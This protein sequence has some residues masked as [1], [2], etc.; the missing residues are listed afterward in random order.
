MTIRSTALK[1]L[2]STG[3]ACALAIVLGLT[4]FHPALSQRGTPAATPPASPSPAV[5]PAATMPHLEL[6]MNEL[7]DSGIGGT[8]T[9]YDTGND[10]T[11]VVFDITEAGKDHPAHIHMGTCDALD[12]EPQ[13]PLNDV[14]DGTSTTLVDVSLDDLL[15]EPHAVDMHLAPD[16]LG[17]LIGCADIA[18]TPVTGSATPTASP[19]PA[20]S[21]SPEATEATTG[22]GT[23]GNTTALPSGTEPARTPAATSTVEARGGT[24]TGTTSGTTST[25]ASGKGTA[26]GA[27]QGV[28][29]PLNSTFNSG[30]NGTV[31][32]AP[33]DGST[34]ILVELRGS[35]TEGDVVHLHP[36]TCT[37]PGDGTWTLNP[38]DAN[39][40]SETVVEFPISELISNGYFVNVHPVD[41]DYDAWLV[42]ANLGTRAGTT[43]PTP[44][45][46][47]TSTTSDGTS[48]VGETTSTQV[49]PQQAGVGAALTW[50]ASPLH[51]V[52]WASGA[53]AIILLGAAL[54]VRRGAYQTTP[55]RW[56]RLGL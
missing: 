42:C 56:H 52:M 14:K 37:A 27:S 26:V 36:G 9:L 25:A 1:P 21:P 15:A 53:A 39:G 32:L 6:E 31:S 23:G 19:S 10:Q 11:I 16:Q 54:I 47:T 44:T 48:G 55:S 5:T 41:G 13:Y 29:I 34:D 24:T 17:T 8:V 51:A 43:A 33:S 7:N 18:G 28:T 12:A 49:L 40:A 3:L 45:G 30:V 4:L 2:V 46:G 50:P 20:A 38:I 22:D 35:F